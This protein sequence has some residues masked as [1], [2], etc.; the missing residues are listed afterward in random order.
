MRGSTLWCVI[1]LETE[2]ILESSINQLVTANFFIPNMVRLFGAVEIS[3]EKAGVGGSIP[4]L[5]I[6]STLLNST[7]TCLFF[8]LCQICAMD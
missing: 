5:A 8:H 3:P 1:S 6:N 4:S 7:L 2:S